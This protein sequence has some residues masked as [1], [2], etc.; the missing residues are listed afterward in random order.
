MD[1]K[2]LLVLVEKGM[3]ST[4]DALKAVA[5]ADQPLPEAP[6]KPPAKSRSN[7]TWQGIPLRRGHTGHVLFAA[8]TLGERVGSFTVQELRSELRRNGHTIKAVSVS[9]ILTDLK[10]FGAVMYQQEHRW[11]V[12]PRGSRLLDQYIERDYI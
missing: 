8:V 1:I 3:L 12:T 2:T 11:A 7:D 10:D 9:P 5:E 4:E 6:P